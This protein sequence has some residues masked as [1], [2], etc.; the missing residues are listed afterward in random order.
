MSELA[1]LSKGGILSTIG[2]TPL[3]GL[4]RIFP[5]LHFNLHAKLE[6]LNPGGSI[7]DRT[8]MSLLR[9]AWEQGLIDSA[10]T[11]VESSSG[12]LGIGIA[13]FCAWMR[14]RFIC[15]VDSRTTRTNLKVMQAYGAEIE[16]VRDCDAP[17]GDLLSARIERVKS[18]C[19]AIPR[20][21]WPNQYANPANARAHLVTMREIYEGLDGEVDYVFAATSTCG[22]LRGCSEYVAAHCGGTKIVAVDA[23]GSV[24]FGGP[25]GPRLIPG[26]GASRVP[27]LYRPGLEYR[28][29][30]VTDLDCVI[31]C[32][33]LL[34][35]EA[36]FAGGSSG[37][38]VSAIAAMRD[39]IPAG[40]NCVAILCDRGERYLDTVYSPRWVA[41]MFGDVAGLYDRPARAEWDLQ[42]RVQTSAA[43]G[44]I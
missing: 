26:H 27:E 7:K 9:E 1:G 32:Y 25:A 24:I 16:P 35:R 10:S 4:N 20:S 30:A 5:D 18:L 41:E 44:G 14:L 21:F 42:T 40:V 31:G 6:M 11:V 39:Q 37:G 29:V 13:Q 8:A 12:N 28:H 38:V 17:G 43:Y 33:R 36:I 22:T 23:A 34:R 2:N 3:I 15:V 19:A